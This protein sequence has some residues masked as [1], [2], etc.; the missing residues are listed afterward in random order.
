MDSEVIYF[1]VISRRTEEIHFM[2][3][4]Y[5][6]AYT[7]E[8]S[9]MAITTLVTQKEGNRDH[10]THAAIIE[11]LFPVSSNYT[12]TFNLHQDCR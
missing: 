9:R 3:D 4:T 6:E 1:P 7:E 11:F 5:N 8:L 2:C 12:L 10:T